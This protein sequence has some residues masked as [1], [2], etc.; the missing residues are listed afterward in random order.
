MTR[1]L[2]HSVTTWNTVAQAWWMTWA[3][4][5]SDYQRLPPEWFR[6]FDP[7]TRDRIVTIQ[8]KPNA[9]ITV[10]FSGL[11]LGEVEKSLTITLDTHNRV[12]TLPG[13]WFSNN[14]LLRHTT[15]YA[16]GEYTW[17]VQNCNFDKFIENLPRGGRVRSQ[18]FVDYPGSY[19]KV[20]DELTYPFDGIISEGD[21]WEAMRREMDIG[22]AGY[23][24][25]RNGSLYMLPGAIRTPVAHLV[26]GDLE[27]SFEWYTRA[28]SENIANR[29]TMQ[30]NSS[31]GNE[32]Q[33]EEIRPH[34]NS[35][36]LRQD[37]GATIDVDFGIRP[38]LISRRAAFR[39][40][41]I[42]LKRARGSAH[43]TL[44]LLPGENLKNWSIFAGD[45]V[46]LTSARLNLNTAL[47]FVT[48]A[49]YNNDL[50][51][52]L[53][54]KL[55]P[56]S[57]YNDVEGEPYPPSTKIE[58][59][60]NTDPK[61]PPTNLGRGSGESTPRSPGGHGGGNPGAAPGTPSSPG[62]GPTGVPGGR[63]R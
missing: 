58:Y 31:D 52:E 41:A 56:S 26:E 28:S 47:C 60:S 3:E 4:T 29:V 59:A 19:Y 46:T 20:K 1:Y 45:Y 16:A 55:E 24:P 53:A 61:A 50:S 14:G 34:Q 27:G 36:F 18:F 57:T 62:G 17:T 42:L 54:I 32:L 2:V 49:T 33:R 11:L 5:G 30:L 8:F 23:M 37:G 21:D 35:R 6:P 9:E 10:G 22:Y 48:N 44:R 13:P 15:S 39:L 40:E 12:V 25:D 43:G 63:G 38:F 51:V 7:R